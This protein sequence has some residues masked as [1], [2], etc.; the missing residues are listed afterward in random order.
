[1]TQ[2]C[3]LGEV[4]Y[5]VDEQEQKSLEVDVLGQLM[6]PHNDTLLI[7][8]DLV[9]ECKVLAPNKAWIFFESS[10]DVADSTIL[11]SVP[12]NEP[13]LIAWHMLAERDDP[14]EKVGPTKQSCFGGVEFDDS[15]DKRKKDSDPLFV[16]ISKLANK[17]HYRVKNMDAWGRGINSFH[18]SACWP[19]LVLDGPLMA[20]HFDPSRGQIALTSTSFVRLHWYGGTLARHYTPVDVVAAEYL[21]KYLDEIFYPSWRQLLP[22][23][24][25]ASADLLD[26][27]LTGSM[28]N[29]LSKALRS[30][31]RPEC[32]PR[33]TALRVAKRAE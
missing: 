27:A 23:I 22:E 16:H 26:A 18:P 14:L 24:A 2:D 8:A 6:Y 5:V 12:G 31:L 1:M 10:A 3:V 15:N 29:W 21:P 28:S 20:G 33:W 30:P 25:V 11:R 32:M 13:A 17:A 9:V 19:L 7:S 4:P